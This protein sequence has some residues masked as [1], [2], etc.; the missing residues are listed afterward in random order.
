MP[1]LRHDPINQRWVIIA[2]ERAKRPS[3]FARPGKKL[4]KGGT[5]TKNNCPFCPGQEKETPPEVFALRLPGTEPDTP[6]W[7]VRVVPN[8]F[9][10]LVPESKGTEEMA[11]LYRWREGL[12]VHEVI[13]EGPDHERELWDYDP[14]HTVQ[15]LKTWR[16]RYLQHARD[17]RLAYAQIFKNFGTE[18]GAS[19]QHPHS[20]LIAT[21]LVPSA[22]RQEI[23]RAEEYLEEKESCIY[24][25]LLEAELSQGA[26]LIA[27]NKRFLAFCPFASRFPFETWIL[28]RQHQ[29]SFGE[30]TD[31]QLEDLASVMQDV[32]GRLYRSLDGPPFNLVL[33]TAPLH[34]PSP[35]YHWYLQ[36]LPR[37][38]TVAGFEWGTDIFINPTP[39]EHAA[40]FLNEVSEEVG[41]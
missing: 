29:S 26:R 32:L 37:L 39:P 22:V 3:D 15:V 21:P 4:A 6:G 7:Q 5:K 24:C 14:E 31:E 35:A 1:E 30:V 19:L 25:D 36:L 34:E 23:E 9:A 18:A 17:E 10:A 16:Q 27:F 28:P 40:Q 20:Q 33:R 11:G 13:I 38:T 2:T 41:E 8:K 12:G